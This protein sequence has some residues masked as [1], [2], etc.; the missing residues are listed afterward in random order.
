MRRA[1]IVRGVRTPF[2]KAFGEFTSL[3]TI[4][5]GGSAVRSLLR[6]THVNPKHVDGVIWGGVVLP[7]ASPN[8]GR[9]IILDLG[10]P[11]EI[12]AV[13]VTRACASGLE[14]ITSA[15]AKIE[16][17]EAD[18]MIAGGS[19]STSNA[20]VALPTKFIQKLGP[21][22]MGK[23]V[24]PLDYVQ[25]LSQL[26]PLTDVLPRMPRGD[27][28]ILS[29][30]GGDDDNPLGRLFLADFFTNGKSIHCRQ[31]H[32]QQN[33]I[34]L[35]IHPHPAADSAVFNTFNFVAIE[36]QYIQ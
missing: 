16:R 32:V 7:P 11:R 20:A 28:V 26:N 18:I 24:R 8:V 3:D 10:L 19:D 29:A 21:L 2:V 31:H 27:D 9:E 15:A 36:Y 4:A 14:A 22:M 34:K 17:G 35:L 30:F 12:E 6:Q 25:A 13:T 23:R 1:V 33:Q 5:L